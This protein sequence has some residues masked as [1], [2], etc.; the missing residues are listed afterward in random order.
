MAIAK[1][2]IASM[3]AVEAIMFHQVISVFAASNDSALASHELR[4][5]L[6]VVR[7]NL[8]AARGKAGEESAPTTGALIKEAEIECDSLSLLVDDLLTLASGDARDWR[9]ERRSCDAEAL[10]IESFEGMDEKAS[11]MD[12]VLIP[13]LPDTPVPPVYADERRIVQ[14]LKILLENAFFYSPKGREVRLSLRSEGAFA[15]FA[16]SDHGLGVSAED[17]RRIFERFYQVDQSR[18]DAFHHGLG[19]SIAYEIVEAHEGRIVV[20]D[21]EGGGSIFKVSLPLE[22]EGRQVT[23]FSN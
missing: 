4:S 14:V 13:E 22:K 23:T 10:L 20:C 21:N 16:V 9:I 19:L 12:V 8:E 15:V 2:T 7:L 11:S 3:P 18:G 1:M 5:P 6:S 17:K